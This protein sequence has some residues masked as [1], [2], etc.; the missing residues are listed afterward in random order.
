[1]WLPAS[2]AP[3]QMIEWTFKELLGFL[4]NK[5]RLPRFLTK[6]S[7]SIPLSII[8]VLGLGST[9]F[10][11]EGW[12]ISIVNDPNK[13]V[14]V[15][16]RKILGETAKVAEA[17]APESPELEQLSVECPQGSVCSNFKDDDFS[18]WSDYKRSD[19]NPR[20]IIVSRDSKYDSP[21]L[22]FKKETS[23]LNFHLYVKALPTNKNKGNIVLLQKDVWR[24]IIGD[25]DYNS[26]SCQFDYSKDSAKSPEKQFLSTKGYKR[27]SPDKDIIVNIKS[28]LTF[29][30]KIELTVSLKYLDI[31][32]QPQSPELKFLFGIPSPDIANFKELVGVSVID[33]KKE[34]IEV[35]FKELRLSKLE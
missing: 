35:E 27:I 4:L 21:P 14:V 2:D 31:D 5:L 12:R 34:N 24:C 7:V 29:E 15:F 19:R 18:G 13:K 9:Y 17:A 6:P 32:N 3:A 11:N 16:E 10:Y 1:M 26:V 23:G 33:P 28:Y 8:T 22:L 25:A 30:N 20:S